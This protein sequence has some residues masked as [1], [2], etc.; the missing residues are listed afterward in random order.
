LLLF[1]E[2]AALWFPQGPGI[3]RVARAQIEF[4]NIQRTSHTVIR[5]YECQ[6]RET[7]IDS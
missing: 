1:A 5:V 3:A 2:T 4:S 7:E 6:F